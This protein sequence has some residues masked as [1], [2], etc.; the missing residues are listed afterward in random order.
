M[1]FRILGALIAALLGSVGILSFD[2]SKAS[3]VEFDPLCTNDGSARVEFLYGLHGGTGGTSTQTQTWEHPYFAVGFQILSTNP[4][5]YNME[6]VWSTDSAQNN[7]VS[8]TRQEY[9]NAFSPEG[10]NQEGFGRWEGGTTR[11]ML[12]DTDYYLTVNLYLPNG[13]QFACSPVLELPA[14]SLTEAEAIGGMN[15]WPAF[16]GSNPYLPGGLFDTRPAAPVADEVMLDPDQVIEVPAE[17]K[18]FSEIVG[19][20][21]S[22]DGGESWATADLQELTQ[23]TSFGTQTS[24][25]SSAENISTAVYMHTKTSFKT[26]ANTPSLNAVFGISEQSDGTPLVSGE[27][28]KIALRGVNQNAASE[29][30]FGEKS[31]DI[32]YVMG[33]QSGTL[34]AAISG[35]GDGSSAAL[36][37]TGVE[38]NSLTPVATVLVSLGV[39]LS[40]ALGLIVIRGRRRRSTLRH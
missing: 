4:S 3:A 18:N 28:Y 24:R 16:L 40:G 2:V 7:V 5:R 19:V 26:A 8:T 15:E 31:A 25:N 23:G 14:I 27:N 22:T 21:Y 13:D 37:A 20:E 10:S 35:T 38:Q 32:C 11:Y 36:A 12:Y 17:F 30:L 33:Q 29:S 1:K 34:C 39:I 9:P 6:L